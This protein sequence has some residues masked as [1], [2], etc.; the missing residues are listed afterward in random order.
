[1]PA[2][3]FLTNLN[4]IDARA[5]S[6]PDVHKKIPLELG[7]VRYVAEQHSSEKP[8]SPWQIVLWGQ[9]AHFRVRPV[10]TSC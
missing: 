4:E 2:E 6:I 9:S 10:D 7:A 5:Q 8:S 1:M 3:I